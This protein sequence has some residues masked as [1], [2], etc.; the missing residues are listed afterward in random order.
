[1]VSQGWAEKWV[2]GDRR[3]QGVPG[4]LGFGVIGRGGRS[5]EVYAKSHCW[6]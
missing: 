6:F 1:M 5:G 4:I 3:V 2:G